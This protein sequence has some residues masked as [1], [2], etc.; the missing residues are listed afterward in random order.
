MAC[1]SNQGD[2]E[3]ATETGFDCQ[4]CQHYC[5]AEF[6][7]QSHIHEVGLYRATV[8]SSDEKANPDTTLEL[9]AYLGGQSNLQ[10]GVGDTVEHWDQAPVGSEVI[11]LIANYT[12]GSSGS[13]VWLDL[14]PI[15]AVGEAS[16]TDRTYDDQGN[17]VDETIS[18][19][20]DDFAAMMLADDCVKT[21]ALAGI[22]RQCPI[23]EL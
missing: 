15:D 18:R 23:D 5:L 14:I 21:M 2:P 1:T 9:T 7:D 3:G 13:Y 17:P 4:V 10:W 11:V 19:P 20:V 8:V 16:C 6:P 22:D 12:D